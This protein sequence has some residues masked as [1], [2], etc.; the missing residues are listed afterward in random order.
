ME[1]INLDTFYGEKFISV[2]PGELIE[3]V[4]VAVNDN[5]VTID[6]GYKYEGTVQRSE[7]EDK[8]PAAG[9][10]LPV[11]V[12][13][14]DDEKGRI[15]LTH[16]GAKKRIAIEKINKALREKTSV[17]GIVKERVKGGFIVDIGLNSFL[18][19]SLAGIKKNEEPDDLIGEEIEVFLESF[20]ASRKRAV[21]NRKELLE[22]RHKNELRRFLS[23]LRKGDTLQGVISGFA[24]FGAFVDVGPMK[25]LIRLSDLSWR[26][27]DHP[28]KVVSEGDRVS[29]IVLHADVE[30]EKLLLGLKQ[31]EK[32]EW[33]KRAEKIN[34]GK[35]IKGTIKKVTTKG[36]F[37]WIGRGIDG[38]LPLEELR[39]YTRKL[40]VLREGDAITV[41]VG[42]VDLIN[43]EIILKHPTQ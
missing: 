15:F 35:I 8:L 33:H 11:I 34:E 2:S 42:S 5:D 28:S 41:K 18:P 43:R 24:S 14:I 13:K 27:V 9:D 21:L 26:K 19:F 16:K 23:G 20:D 32:T 1:K 7:F 4:V 22:G 17:K 36:I 25:G 31:A 3:G 10:T 37:V 30:Q 12:K 38:F 6:F 40:H 29:V 39:S